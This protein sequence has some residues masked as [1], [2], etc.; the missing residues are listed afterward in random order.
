MPLQVVHPE[1]PAR[2]EPAT[3]R[4]EYACQLIRAEASAANKTDSISN[5]SPVSGAVFNDDN[6]LV[7]GGFAI[8]TPLERLTFYAYGSSSHMR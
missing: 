6:G 4:L 2:A 7:S 3:D 5:V 1:S 8:Q